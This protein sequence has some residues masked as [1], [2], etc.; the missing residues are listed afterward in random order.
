MPDDPQ[1][2]DPASLPLDV[3]EVDPHVVE[4]AEGKADAGRDREVVELHRDL[5]APDHERST[6]AS[7]AVAHRPRHKLQH[8]CGTGEQQLGPGQTRGLTGAV[9]RLERPVD[10]QPVG[11][12][13][14]VGVDGES[15]GWPRHSSTVSRKV[16]A[17]QGRV[18]ARARTG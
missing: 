7:Q 16:G 17:P 13:R 10:V 15:A 18:L 6:A 11:R 12:A 5:L 1:R 4:L 2:A 14:R 3:G 8:L 9:E